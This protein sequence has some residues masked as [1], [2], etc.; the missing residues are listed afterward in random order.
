MLA[1]DDRDKLV[2]ARRE[3]VRSMSDSGYSRFRPCQ[4]SGQLASV[5]REE[6]RKS[7]TNGHCRIGPVASFYRCPGDISRCMTSVYLTRSDLP[8]TAVNLDGRSTGI[9]RTRTKSSLEGIA[10][11]QI[12]SMPGKNVERLGSL[13]VFYRPQILPYNFEILLWI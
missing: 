8:D 11:E 9:R 2:M 5:P 6:L 4:P 3:T 1:I 13:Q 7:Q 10:A 12:R